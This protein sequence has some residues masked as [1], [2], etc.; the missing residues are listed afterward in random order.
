MGQKHTLIKGAFI[1]TMTGFVTRLIGF[2]YRIFLSQAF[3][4]EGVGIYQLIFPVYALGFSLTCAGIEIAISRTVAQKNAIGKS[5]EGRT[6]LYSGCLFSML[7]SVLFMLLIQKQ[8]TFIAV[9][10]LNEPRCERLLLIIS[11]ALP[12]SSL[13][14]CIYGYFLG[15]KETKTPAIS[16]FIEQIVRVG[17]VFILY[18]FSL[19]NSHDPNIIVAVAGIVFGE[20]ASSVFCFFSY[21]H[22]KQTFDYSITFSSLKR[23]IKE[24]FNLSI[25]LTCNRV[26][27]NILQSI[28]AISI[29][30]QLQL[31][32]YNT[33]QS[34]SI[35]GVLTGMALPCILFPSALTNSVATMM[36]PTVAELQ[37][38]SNKHFLFS[39][40]KKVILFCSILGSVCCILFIFTG[41]FIG[42]HIF[43]SNLAG[44]FLITMAWMCPFLYTN[45]NLISIINGLGKT[46]YSFVFNTI[47]LSLR[48]GSI[49]YLIP[50]YGIRG[51]LLGLLTSQL[52][53]FLLC[54]GYLYSFSRITF[55]RT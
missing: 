47:G 41:S 1:L 9:Q 49:Y 5:E 8:S 48:I 38:A 32:G 31:F 50:L 26:L 6:V 18:R 30:I 33:S 37:T 27:L 11:Y 13:H 20:F 54:I 44:D 12:F 25:P 28:E 21:Q 29:P 39:I 3:G 35:Y 17:S 14:S 42:K 2:F 19:Q 52:V 4:E 36:L 53:I 34:L 15:L 51:Y 24:L 40:T 43:H 45:S 55:T 23:S 46:L 16:Q 22:Q 10:L 7:F